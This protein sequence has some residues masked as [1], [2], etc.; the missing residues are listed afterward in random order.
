MTRTTLTTL[1]LLAA[2]G[3]TAW[4]LG[5][6]LGAGV[7][8]GALTGALFTGLSLLWQR[9]QLLHH[10][11]RA[12]RAMVE[13]F[14]AKLLVILMAAFALRFLPALAELLD[15]RSFLVAFAAAAFALLAIG[16]ADNLRTAKERRA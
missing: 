3:F 8:A 9:H 2:A 6:A 11:E 13:G 1:C 15:W 5:G 10:P 4:Q 12:L 14:I 16:T 7:L